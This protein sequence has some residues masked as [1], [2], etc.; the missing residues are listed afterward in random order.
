MMRVR[1]QSRSNELHHATMIEWRPQVATPARLSTV[2]ETS[3]GGSASFQT[4][5][6]LTDSS[7]DY[8]V[9]KLKQH[10][11]TTMDNYYTNYLSTPTKTG[12]HTARAR[13]TSFTRGNLIINHDEPSSCRRLLSCSQAAFRERGSGVASLRSSYQNLINESANCKYRSYHYPFE[14]KQHVSASRLAEDQ[15][16]RRQQQQQ[17][18]RCSSLSRYDEADYNVSRIWLPPTYEDQTTTHRAFSNAGHPQVFCSQPPIDTSSSSTNRREGYND[19]RATSSSSNL[20][21][22]YNQRYCQCCC[23][24]SYT[25][26]SDNNSHLTKEESHT[27]HAP[28]Q[29]NNSGKY[30][31]KINRVRFSASF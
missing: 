9:V 12:N 20:Q 6:R 7:E 4:E 15:Y 5:Y 21:T 1:P 27:G 29:L 30:K 13:S 22:Y 10:L 28:F 14:D 3:V 17:R 2:L 24:G 11:P 26:L 19:E 16:K 23:H 18:S 25:P 31:V 8:S